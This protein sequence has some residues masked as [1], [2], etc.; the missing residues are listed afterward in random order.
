VYKEK[1]YA[2]VI[3]F[4]DTVKTDYQ[5]YDLTGTSEQEAMGQAIQALPSGENTAAYYALDIALDRIAQV[6][7]KNME[8]D[9][10][11]DTEDEAEKIYL[12][13]DFKKGPQTGF[14][15]WKKDHYTLE[16]IKTS[17]GFTLGIPDGKIEMDKLSYSKDSNTV[18]FIVSGL[19]I[20]DTP[21]SV[22]REEVSQWFYDG[23]RLRWN[24]EYSS[25]SGSKKMRT[26]CW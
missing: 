8:R 26:Y 10:I 15:F 7:K 19:K 1:L 16:N 24:S 6:Q 17:E 22:K 12:E 25:S 11:N 5:L 13:A 14:M 21:Y 18:P 2:D 9:P 4:N 3:G 23:G 20:G